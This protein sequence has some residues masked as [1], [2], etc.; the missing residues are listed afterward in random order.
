MKNNAPQFFLENIITVNLLRLLK[1]VWTSFFFV[2]KLYII[3]NVKKY[4]RYT[5]LL[6]SVQL[7]DKNVKKINKLEK[8]FFVIKT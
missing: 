3:T 1:I 7:G 8:T 2:K 5:T 6:F 4:R